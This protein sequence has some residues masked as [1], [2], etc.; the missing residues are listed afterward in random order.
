MKQKTLN[1]T[2]PYRLDP[3]L[4]FSW[5]PD[6]YHFMQLT[7]NPIQTASSLIHTHRLPDTEPSR[8]PSV[9][10]IPVDGRPPVRNTRNK[11]RIWI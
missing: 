8:L 7:S 2:E 10:P 5:S 4:V 3:T 6:L 9:H 11:K 1:E